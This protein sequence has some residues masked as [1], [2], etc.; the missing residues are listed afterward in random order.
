MVHQFFPATAHLR[1]G[2][3]TWISVAKTEVSSY[4]CI[5]LGYP[6]SRSVA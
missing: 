2:Q 1:Q 6:E 4:G 5:A 3:T